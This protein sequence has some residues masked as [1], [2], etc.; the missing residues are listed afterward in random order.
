MT[1]ENLVSKCESENGY[2]YIDGKRYVLLEQPLDTYDGGLL[3]R[4]VRFN[5]IFYDGKAVPTYTVELTPDDLMVDF[6]KALDR[7]NSNS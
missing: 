6:C 2:L 4:A 1:I 7:A 3:A 5:D